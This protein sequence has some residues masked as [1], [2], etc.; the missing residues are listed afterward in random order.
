MLRRP[1]VSR[2]IPPLLAIGLLLTSYS[3]VAAHLSKPGAGTRAVAS[4]QADVVVYGGTPGGVLAA[5]TASRAGVSVILIEP[6]AHVGGMTSNGLTVADV[7]RRETIGGYTKEFF[8]RVEV[9]EGT[10]FGRWRHQ[11][12]NGE[13]AFLDMLAST[14][15]R[16]IHGERLA[17]PAGVIKTG[18]RIA[19]ILMESGLVIAGKAF[20]DASYEGD[21][22]A[23][24]GVTY[25]IGREATSEYGESLAGVGNPTAIF[26]PPPGTYV[27]NLP[28]SPPGPVGSS[29]ER[30][31]NSN[32]RLCFSTAEGNRVPFV[33]PDGYDPR[34]YDLIA[35]YIDYRK[36]KGETPILQWVLAP[37][38]VVNNKY[39]VNEVGA[40][41]MGVAGLNYG[42]PEGTYAE[43]DEIVAAHRA[44]AEGFLWFLATDPRVPTEIRDKMATYGL[45]KDE[46]VD[47]GH[48]P[49]LL[50]LREGR[51]MVGETVLVQEDTLVY[52]AKPDLI[53][54]ASYNLDSHFVSR[55]MED[56]TVYMEGGFW[57]TGSPIWAIPYGA[58]I[59]LENEV[60]NLLVP[61]TASASHVAMASLRMEPHYMIMGEASGQAAAMVVKGGGTVQEVDVRALQ[62]ALRAHGAY[63]INPLDYGDS[64]FY[65]DILWLLKEG[66]SGGCGGGNYCPNSLT[67]RAQM[68]AFLVRAL[69]LPPAS[70]DFFRDDDTNIHE[71]H[72]NV[73]AEAGITAGCGGG[74]FCPESN[75]TR[76]Q[77]ATLLVRALD[78]PHTDDDYFTDDGASQHEPDINALA[79]AGVTGGCRPDRF[80]PSGAVTRG[81]MA[82]FLHRAPID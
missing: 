82:A 4:V 14:D 8:D 16:V 5:V 59:P 27:D 9:L 61:V 53:G 25:R 70:R 11:P 45:C 1:A 71:A 75:V 80:C 56:G 15:V 79:A 19:S 13:R 21:L 47:N 36:S 10:P 44:Y 63:L 48:W 60:T 74:R 49:R 20:I 26:T 6:S 29:D 65:H 37:G 24:A 3:P 17:E 62:R 77:M 30:I 73:L 2:T 32:F 68:A 55:W 33:E 76:A 46:F 31:Q 7:G 52:R 18:T 12:K 51:R 38:N 64:S 66:I 23:D 42:F 81:Q 50:Y 58:L 22:M 78:L 67:T 69:D 39:D 57:L 35:A 41:S 34:H 40:I 54:A 28:L 72:I 43:R